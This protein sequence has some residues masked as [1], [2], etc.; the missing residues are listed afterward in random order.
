MDVRVDKASDEEH[1]PVHGRYETD[2]DRW[3]PGQAGVTAKAGSR[4][5]PLRLPRLRSLYRQRQRLC[6]ETLGLWQKGR[7]AD[8]VVLAAAAKAG[9]EAEV[10]V[11]P[12][13]GGGTVCCCSCLCSQPRGLHQVFAGGPVQPAPSIITSRRVNA[14]QN[15][16]S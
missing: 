7:A 6:R 9:G 15:K 8:R 12:C 14:L 11:C 16:K 5:P 10:I 13:L 4:L 2:E 3:V 1:S